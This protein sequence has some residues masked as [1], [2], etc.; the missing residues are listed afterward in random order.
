MT[1]LLIWRS[2][3]LGSLEQSVHTSSGF[4]Q[5]FCTKCAGVLFPAV[6]LPIVKLTILPRPVRRLWC[7]KLHTSFPPHVLLINQHKD[8]FSLP[9]RFRLFVFI[10][11]II[12]LYKLILFVHYPLSAFSYFPY[13]LNCICFFFWLF[14]CFHWSGLALCCYKLFSY[15]YLTFSTYLLLFPLISRDCCLFLS[16]RPSYYGP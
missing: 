8:N 14:S 16:F 13:L 12:S 3:N 11:V 10:Y 2:G 15:L 7:S 9:L 5:A 6:T 4:H 1:W